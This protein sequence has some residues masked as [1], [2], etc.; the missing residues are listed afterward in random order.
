[1]DHFGSLDNFLIATFQGMDVFLY[2]N[3]QGF[4]P[5]IIKYYLNNNVVDAMPI[6]D[7]IANIE[8]LFISGLNPINNSKEEFL[9]FL[10]YFIY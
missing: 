9:I 5:V 2:R 8:K 1:M 7:F 4:S 3:Q 10:N 6:K